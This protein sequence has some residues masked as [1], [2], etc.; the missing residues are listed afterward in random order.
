MLYAS[1]PVQSI[2]HDTP[3]HSYVG[4]TP[5]VLGAIVEAAG[6]SFVDIGFWGSADYAGLLVATRS[7]PDHTQLTEPGRGDPG[8]P[9]ICW[10]WARNG[11]SPASAAGGCGR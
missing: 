10:V 11:A 3:H 5:T 4:I 9:V 8:L 6:F 1:V 2:P 7:W